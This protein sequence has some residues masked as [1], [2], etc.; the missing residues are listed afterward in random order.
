[1]SIKYVRGKKAPWAVP[2]PYFLKRLFN[3]AHGNAS[4]TSS[5]I[6]IREMVE[7]NKLLTFDP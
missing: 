2:G 5:I 3:K 4:P 7:C 6:R 1:M